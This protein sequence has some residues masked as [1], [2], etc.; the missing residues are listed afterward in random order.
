MPFLRGDG[1]ATLTRAIAAFEARTAAELVVVVEPRA[2]HY[3]HVA[4]LFGAAAALA[5]LAFLLYGEPSFAL[6]WFLID[7]VLAGALVGWLA[8]GWAAL[9]RAV[10]PAARRAA[11]ALRAAR[12]AFTARGVADTRGRTGVLVYVAVGEREAVVIADRGVREVVPVEAWAAACG[13]LRAA[14]ARGEDATAIAPRL[15]A[16]AEVCAAHLPRQGDD[17]NE[18]IDEVDS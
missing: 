3:L 13:A 2:G 14:V 15:A 1:K 10:T 5:M 17:E 11:W 18:L 12:A 16:L 7:P 9:E 8:S 4:V 6:H